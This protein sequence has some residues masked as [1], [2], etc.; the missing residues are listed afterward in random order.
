MW[1]LSVNR[2]MLYKCQALI[3]VDSDALSH[4][5]SA[6][7]KS[8]CFQK[9]I[10]QDQNWH[11]LIPSKHRGNLRSTKDFLGEFDDLI[12]KEGMGQVSSSQKHCQASVFRTAV[13]EGILFLPFFWKN[14]LKLL[15]NR[16]IKNT[17]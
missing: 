8:R 15:N 2:R 3:C 12:K 13:Q 17:D 16:K 4:S 9:P 1:M 11:F 7:Q 6:L 10:P 14:I 5:P